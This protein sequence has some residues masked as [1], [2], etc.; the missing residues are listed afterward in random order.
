MVTM[1]TMKS[2]RNTSLAVAFALVTSFSG[3]AAKANPNVPFDQWLAGVRQ[4]ALAQGVSPNLVNQ[5]LTGLQ[6]ISKIVQLDKAQPEFTQSFADYR[7]QRV[8][9]S[10][11]ENG[12]RMLVQHWDELQKASK[13]YGVPPQYI[14]ALWGMETSYGGF[15]GGYNVV[16]ALATLAW[17]GRGGTRPDRAEYF[18]KE[19]LTAL[20]IIDQGHVSLEQMKG[21][22]AG[23][24]GQVQFMPSSFQ[25]LAV[26]GDG[27]G[28]KDIWTNLSDAFHSAAN[29][30]A[31][32]GWKHDERWGRRVTLPSGFSASDLGADKQKTL[33]EWRAMGLKQENGSPIPVVP[34]MRASV[35]APD[36]LSGPA[37]LV[38]NNFRTVK[39]WNNSDKF[40]L[41]VGLLADAIAAAA[42]K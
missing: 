33:A 22:W 25:R 42:P 37:Y 12:Q 17:N 16:E 11:I 3:S 23:A 10:R 19:L 40:A 38:Y 7:S 35:V 5:A 2:I 8:N 21:S 30:L 34:G 39:N 15:T 24:M 26:D 1:W 36:G 28:R 29:Y 9:R 4:E 13:K 32:N 18:R 6:P 27:D 14:V 41:S 31:Q 20:K